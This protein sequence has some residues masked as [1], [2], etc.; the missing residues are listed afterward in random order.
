MSIVGRHEKTFLSLDLIE[1]GLRSYL[2]KVDWQ[3]MSVQYL[4][5]RVLPLAAVLVDVVDLPVEEQYDLHLMN[6]SAVTR[7]VDES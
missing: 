1:E 2:I 4:E 6:V 7:V 5:G 3:N